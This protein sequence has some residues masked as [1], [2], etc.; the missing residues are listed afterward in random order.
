MTRLWVAGA[1]LSGSEAAWQL[2]R[3]GFEVDLYEMRP[4]T[5]TLAHQT[6][7][8]GELVCS[9]SLGADGQTV[10]GLLKEELRRCD[11][12]IMRAADAVP[13]PAGR[14]LA[15]DRAAFAR[16]ITDRLVNLPNV[17]LKR[18]ELTDL[19][20]GPGILATGPMTSP[21]LARRLQEIAGADHLAFFDA[22][23]PVVDASTLDLSKLYAK[24]RHVDNPDGRADYLNSPLDKEQYER[25]VSLLLDA[26]RAVHDFE[27]AGF[28]EGCMPLEVIASRGPDTLR[29]GP[30]R[31]VGLERPDGT[32][33]Y[34]VVQLRRENLAASGYNLVGF[35]TN[36]KW[37]AQREVFR[38]LPGLEQAEFF[39]YGVMH[40]NI[41]LNAPKVLL[42]L[43]L[44]DRPVW[45]AGQL[46]GVEGYLE[47]TAMGLVAA[48]NAAAFLTGAEPPCWPD[49][50]AVG[51]LLVHL[52]REVKNFQ[53]QNVNRGIFPPLEGRYRRKDRPQK[54][55]A[56]LER[57][58]AAF[59]E[60]T[61]PAIAGLKK[62]TP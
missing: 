5:S 38:T 42:N 33:P 32:R 48:L 27:G 45:V 18:V 35:Q 9:N 8:C 40:R 20:E 14:A 46:T 56:L 50:T 59:A 55:A 4:A 60:R 30:L 26:P 15:V 37:P 43:R 10:G 3:R 21:M 58:R 36:L 6:D 34:A 49:V 47:S 7:L 2:A 11:S 28:F 13:V 12:L 22:V 1:G 61:A 17:T 23:A 53:P 41:F 39:R 19:P 57:A 16:F 31:P 44:L 25:F 62:S 24:D 54:D 52:G 51:A 29:F